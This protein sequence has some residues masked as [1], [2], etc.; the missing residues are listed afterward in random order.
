MEALL[1]SPHCLGFPIRV[2]SDRVRTARDTFDSF[3]GVS[4]TSTTVPG[5]WTQSV[6]STT[7]LLISDREQSSLRLRVTSEFFCVHI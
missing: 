4:D 7:T 3:L 6:R 2:N 5:A 1:H